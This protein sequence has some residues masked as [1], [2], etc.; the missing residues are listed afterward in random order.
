MINI[1]LLFFKYEQ[2]PEC[3]VVMNMPNY[4][5]FSCDSNDFRRLAAYLKMSGK[6]WKGESL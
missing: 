2:Y 4:L 5:K 1:F 6:S 3:I